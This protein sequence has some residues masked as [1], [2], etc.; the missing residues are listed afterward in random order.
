MLTGGGGGGISDGE[1]E[2]SASVFHSARG[3]VVAWNVFFEGICLSKTS[4]FLSTV[5]KVVGSA[6]ACFGTPWYVVVCRGC[7]ILRPR[8]LSP[9]RSVPSSIVDNGGEWC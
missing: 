7:K 1:T 8:E 3:V 2:I 5:V 6:H 4:L 9:L